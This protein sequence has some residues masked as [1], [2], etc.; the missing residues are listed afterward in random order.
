MCNSC[1][2]RH[3]TAVFFLCALAVPGSAL[4]Q[5]LP[6]QQPS[7]PQLG[8]QMQPLPQQAQPAQSSHRSRQAAVQPPAG[9]TRTADDMTLNRLAGRFYALHEKDANAI[10]KMKAL[11]KEVSGFTKSLQLRP[12][13]ADIGHDAQH[14]LDRIRNQRK[15]WEARVAH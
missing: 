1:I 5:A 11:E 15:E 6:W 7:Q 4:C 8:Q 2:I 3:I 9:D 10:P 13:E 14:L 12:A